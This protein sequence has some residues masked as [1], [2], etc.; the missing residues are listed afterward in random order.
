MSRRAQARPQREVDEAEGRVAG[1][2]FLLFL[3]EF[4][5]GGWIFLVLLFSMGTP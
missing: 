3:A 4:L 2:F 5:V 1:L